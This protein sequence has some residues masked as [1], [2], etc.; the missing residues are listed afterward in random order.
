M[1]IAVAVLPNGM[2]NAHLGRAK[3]VA[4]AKVENGQITNWEEVEVPFADDHDDHH[5]EHHEHHGHHDHHHDHHHHEDCQGCDEHDHDHHDHDHHHHHSG[6][7][8]PLKDF[9]LDN[10]VDYVLVEHIGPG[11]KAV[12]ERTNIKLVIVDDIKGKARDV[13]EGFI[14]E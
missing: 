11:M 2:V 6:H 3:K 1:K 14:Q 5:H 9:M 13:V 4:F 8:E 10:N 7:H 12:F